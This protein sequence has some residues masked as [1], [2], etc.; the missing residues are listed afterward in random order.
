MADLRPSPDA[1]RKIFLFTHPRTASNL[2]LRLFAKHPR[3]TIIDYPFHGVYMTG[4]DKLNRRR[5][6]KGTWTQAD[7][8]EL[9][10][11]QCAFDQLQHSISVA[12]EQV[13]RYALP[14][15]I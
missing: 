1:E 7:T 3:L 4:L 13:C 15:R 12:E 10:T 11:Y 6:E 9:S 2:F 8:D 14:V 5:T